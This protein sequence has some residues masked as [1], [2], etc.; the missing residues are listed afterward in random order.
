MKGPA[1]KASVIV[2]AF[3]LIA[4]VQAAEFSHTARTTF[5]SITST[6]HGTCIS[7]HSGGGASSINI[8]CRLTKGAQT[9]DIVKSTIANLESNSKFVSELHTALYSNAWYCTYNTSR[10]RNVFGVAIINQ[11][12]SAQFCKYQSGGGQQR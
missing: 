11:G 5:C 7:S 8:D 4:S 9:K 6:A 10:F 12:N 3:G 1:R 2:T